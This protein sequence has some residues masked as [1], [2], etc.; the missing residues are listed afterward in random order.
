MGTNASNR[1]SW[2]KEVAGVNYTEDTAPGTIDLDATRDNPNAIT[3][4]LKNVPDQFTFTNTGEQQCVIIYI[5]YHFGGD[6]TGISTVT[7]S[8]GLPVRVEYF[9]LSGER[10]TAPVGGLYIMRTTLRNGRTE[11]KKVVL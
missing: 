10:V 4:T 9:T 3:Y 6:E 7:E 5:E 11:S 8:N 1:T 2:W